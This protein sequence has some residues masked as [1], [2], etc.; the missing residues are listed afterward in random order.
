MPYITCILLYKIVY[1]GYNSLDAFVITQNISAHFT[2]CK[3]IVLKLIRIIFKNYSY[4]TCP[5][6]KTFRC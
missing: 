4:C 3:Q 2:E 5:F 1:K 6:I